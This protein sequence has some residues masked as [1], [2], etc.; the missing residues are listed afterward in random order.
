MIFIDGQETD[1][2]VA[3]L[4]SLVVINWKYANSGREFFSAVIKLIDLKIMGLMARK[5]SA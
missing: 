1:A 3:L 2:V 5:N 4:I